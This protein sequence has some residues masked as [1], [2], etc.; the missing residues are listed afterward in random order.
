M[1]YFWKVIFFVRNN[2]V[3]S[4]TFVFYYHV[5]SGFV[6]RHL[7]QYLLDNDLASEIRVADKMIPTVAYL[8]ERHKTAFANPKVEFMS[9]NLMNK[10]K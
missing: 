2:V 3:Q 4:V 8:N 7:V 6:G 5:G 9:A 1:K 10:S